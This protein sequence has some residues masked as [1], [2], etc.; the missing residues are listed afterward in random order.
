MKKHFIRQI[1]FVISLALIA[2]SFNAV[3]ADYLPTENNEYYTVPELPDY[4]LRKKND[5]NKNYSEGIPWLNEEGFWIGVNN[6]V[7][8]TVDGIKSVIATDGSGNVISISGNPDGPTWEHKV[9]VFS[10][11]VFYLQ[12]KVTKTINDD[13]VV[14][15]GAALETRAFL[16]PNFAGKALYIGLNTYINESGNQV[17]EFSTNQ[18]RLGLGIIA[19]ENNDETSV[20]YD[21]SK[22][23]DITK[24]YLGH[25]IINSRLKEG[26][27][28]YHEDTGTVDNKPDNNPDITIDTYSVVGMKG[29]L[30]VLPDS[31]QDGVF[32]SIV[33]N[34]NKNR[35]I[36][37]DKA[38]TIIVPEGAKLEFLGASWD[39]NESHHP[40]SILPIYGEI[41]GDGKV[42]FKAMREDFILVYGKNDEFTG[43][44]IIDTE[45]ATSS[46]RYH[47]SAVV[48][49]NG[50]PDTG[51]NNAR[52]VHFKT[53]NLIIQSDQ[54]LNNLSSERA[55]TATTR[56]GGTD[57]VVYNGFVDHD[58]YQQYQEYTPEHNL[59][60]TLTLYNDKPTTF[61]GAIGEAYEKTMQSD[62]ST[63]HYYDFTGAIKGLEKT[64]NETL[65]LY[66]AGSDGGIRAESFVVSS[67]QVDF[68]GYFKGELT[69]KSGAAFAPDSWNWSNDD[70]IAK[71]DNSVSVIRYLDNG[72]TIVE[73]HDAVTLDGDVYLEGGA[74][75]EFHFSKYDQK[76]NDVITIT[77][78]HTFNVPE[79]ITSIIDLEFTKS[80]PY[81]WA[82][83]DAEYLLI[84]GGGFPLEETDYSDLL[85]NTYGNMQ[86]LRQFGLLG[87]D[88][89]LYL[90][91]RYYVPEPS[92]WAMM[93]LGVAGLLYWR[94]KNG[95][96]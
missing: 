11:K 85:I 47:H 34:N 87:K 17:S 50:T 23:V 48:F 31:N 44:V 12:D 29:T 6:N 58:D 95:R 1:V 89:N 80:D 7:A 13:S 81:D 4:V 72:T 5:N 41:V 71:G 36:V 66:C 8:T 26:T 83:E 62:A 33:A 39:N 57:A 61:Y 82:T 73:T 64:G 86:T 21:P 40:Y 24:V 88:G 22:A 3:Q 90:V 16:F 42:Q 76:D 28:Q 46:E 96:R 14:N 15:L 25:G 49:G 59:Y 54:T 37:I 9:E 43:D 93:I 18:M 91:T 38:C 56:I 60:E 77:P 67:G 79:G 20:V 69:V 92:T 94:R 2:L 27:Y 68:N 45:D 74:K 65:S 52:S 63:I 19:N 30:Q 10:D 51:L 70:A 55:S 32:R 78:G 53:G 84:K 35:H 75:L